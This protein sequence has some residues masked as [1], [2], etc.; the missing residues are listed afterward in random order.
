M[1]AFI[2]FMSAVIIIY[3]RSPGVTLLDRITNEIDVHVRNLNFFMCN[4]DKI[5]ILGLFP[6]IQNISMLLPGHQPDFG[7]WLKDHLGL[8]FLG[9]GISVTLLGEGM[10]TGRL[11]GVMLEFFLVGYILRWSYVRLANT[12]SLRNLLIYVLIAC[13]ASSAINYGISKELIGTLYAMCLIVIIIPSYV[14]L[15]E[16][17]MGLHHSF[18]L[19]RRRNKTLVFS[20]RTQNK[21]NPS[22]QNYLEDNT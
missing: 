16:V 2:A 21:G 20:F 4:M 5:D 11:I 7:T 8:S 19:I 1:Y 9:G 14:R 6:F 12:H 22:R 10:M 17:Q 3:F 13:R 15:P 18:D